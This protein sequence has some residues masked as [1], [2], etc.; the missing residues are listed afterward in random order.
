[1]VGEVTHNV[2]VKHIKQNHMPPG[3]GGKSLF[4]VREP[5]VWTLIQDVVNNPDMISPHR[6]DIEKMV[7]RKKFA[8]PVGVHGQTRK[9]CYCITVIYNMR[10]NIIVTAYPTM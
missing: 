9:N 10:D 5:N 4:T 3:K 1:M 7:Y 2:N 8:T 6:S